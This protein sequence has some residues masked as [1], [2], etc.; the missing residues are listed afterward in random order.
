[1]CTK[2]G[3]DA[4]ITAVRE[5]DI[6]KAR[7]QL[8]SGKAKVNGWA[9]EETQWTG[10]HYAAALDFP[11]MAKMLLEMGANAS[12]VAK[13]SDDPVERPAMVTPLQLAVVSGD[14]KIVEMLLKQKGLDVNAK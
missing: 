1:M 11:E 2:E 10:L 8:E 3:Q 13:F 14:K 6:D 5:N 9:T 7:E 12:A 4:F